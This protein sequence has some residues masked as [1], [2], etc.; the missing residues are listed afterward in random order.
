MRWPNAMLPSDVPKP[1]EVYESDRAAD[2]RRYVIVVSKE[3]MNRGKSFVGVPITT[4]HVDRRKDFGNCVLLSAQEFPW[5]KEDC[6]SQA[7]EIGVTLKENVVGEPIGKLDDEVFCLV[8][9]SIGY[10]L[11]ATVFPN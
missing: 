2:G 10:M 7:E 3:L 11:D 1:G 5:L 8:I 6:V 4:Q 9:E